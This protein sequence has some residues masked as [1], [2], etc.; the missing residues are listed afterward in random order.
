MVD[1]LATVEEVKLLSGLQSGEVSDEE[2]GSHITNVTSMIIEKHGNP[3]DKSNIIV[4]SAELTY[5]FTGNKRPVYRVDYVEVGGSDIT[6]SG[7]FTA[8]LDEG[9]IT[10]TADIIAD[11]SNERL[12]IEWVPVKAN[13]IAKYKSALEVLENLYI[14]TGDETTHTKITRMKETSGEIGSLFLDDVQVIMSSSGGQDDERQGTTITQD[15]DNR[16]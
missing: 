5:D 14:V 7:S 8:D 15:F 3:I 16:F 1:N 2:I 10:L 13:L 4:D 12:E 9:N 6:S 11:F